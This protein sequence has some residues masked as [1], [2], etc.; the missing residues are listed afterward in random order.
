MKQTES[1]KAFEHQL[2]YQLSKFLN[3]PFLDSPE[4]QLGLRSFDKAPELEQKRLIRSANEAATFLACHDYRFKLSEFISLQ[5]DISGQKGDVRDIVVYLTN[6]KEVG[7]STKNRH[8]A[9]K[10]SRLSD[11]ID[12][13]KGV[14]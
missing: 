1:G 2:A 9:I 7:I 11:K 6:K 4:K 14:D 3:V 8:K 13:G 10:H 12:F 5:P